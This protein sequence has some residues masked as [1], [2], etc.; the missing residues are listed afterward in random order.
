MYQLNRRNINNFSFK[1]SFGAPLNLDRPDANE[2]KSPDGQAIKNNDSFKPSLNDDPSKPKKWNFSFNSKSDKESNF[3]SGANSAPKFDFSSLSKS[4]KSRRTQNRAG[5]RPSY[6]RSIDGHERIIQRE[7]Q[8]AVL[9]SIEDASPEDAKEIARFLSPK[10]LSH[11]K[12]LAKNIISQ[13][14]QSSYPAYNNYYGSQPGMIQI[15]SAQWEQ[16][17]QM[18]LAREAQF[19]T[20]M[21]ANAA[22]MKKIQQIQQ[23]GEYEYEYEYEEEEEEEE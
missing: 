10:I 12:N 6:K 11:A 19:N 8:T 15:P 1:T 3:Q 4:R 23:S 18:S 9:D 16:M 5:R 13:S 2:L 17:V 21:K 14:P 22:L 7:V 20:L